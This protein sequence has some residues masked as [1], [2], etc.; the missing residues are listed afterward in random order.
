MI[1]LHQDCCE[2]DTIKKI[3]ILNSAKNCRQNVDLLSNISKNYW[4]N[5]YK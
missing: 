1:D 5:I 4:M 2:G 3:K